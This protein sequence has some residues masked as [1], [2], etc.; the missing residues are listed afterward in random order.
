MSIHKTV[1]ITGA[2]QGIGA[3]LVKTFLDKGWNVVATSRRI[4]QTTLFDRAGR[5]ELIDG[6]VSDPETA[7]RVALTALEQFGSID[8]LVNNAGIF[9]TKPFLDYT[10]EDLRRLSATNVEGFL[11][12]TKQAVRQMLRQKAGGSIITITS[13][14]TDHPI[15]GVNASL[16]MITKGGLNAITKSLALEFAGDNIRVNAV[17]PG[18]VDTPM[19]ATDS[20]DFLKSLSPMGTI[21][22]VQEIVDGVVYL[23]ESSNITGEVLHVDNGA[24]LGKW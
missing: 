19:H 5:L 9:L 2:S 20:K 3:G 18:I 22:A 16:A 11:H 1:V 17:S 12:F 24:H 4:S 7:E 10:I 14:L 23:A 15:A 13:S 6:D 8:V 21:T